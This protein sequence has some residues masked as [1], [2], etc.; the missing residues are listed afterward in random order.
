MPQADENRFRQYCILNLE[1]IGWIENPISIKGLQSS[2][3]RVEARRAPAVR[4]ATATRA[5]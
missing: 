5:L 2:I 4:C 1:M 3:E